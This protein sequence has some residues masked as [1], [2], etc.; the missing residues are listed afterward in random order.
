VVRQAGA[1]GIALVA[2]APDVT[3]NLVEG[4]A[5]AGIKLVGVAGTTGTSLFEGNTLRRS[6]FA[7]LQLED[8]FNTVVRNNV[9]EQNWMSGIHI[10]KGFVDSEIT[11]NVIRDNRNNTSAGFQGGIMLAHATRSRITGNEIYDSRTGSNRTQDHAVFITSAG[12]SQLTISNNVCRNHTESGIYVGNH[13]LFKGTVTDLIITGNTCVSNNA[14]GLH[15]EQT[16]AGGLRNVSAGENVFSPNGRGTIQS[17][18]ALLTAVSSDTIAPAVAVTAPTSG[19]TV[20][21][22]VTIAANAADNTGVSGVRFSIDGVAVGSEVTAAPYAATWNSASVANGQHTITA[23]A[24]DAAGNVSKSSIIVTVSNSAADTAAPAVSNGSPMGVLAAET[25]TATLQVVTNE[26]ATCRYSSTMGTAF[27]SMPNAF[28][29]TGTMT[30]SAML[31]SVTA[32]TKHTYFVRCQDA[33]GNA[34][35]SD[36]AITFT[37][38]TANAAAL[39][40]AELVLWLKS[41]T[42]VLSHSGLVSRWADQSG[43]GNDAVQLSS[44]A[45]PKLVPGVANGLPALDFDGTADMLRVANNPSLDLGSG[46]FTISYWMRSP[47]TGANNGHM[48]KGSG[49]Y[50][51]N[52]GGFEFRTQRTLLEFTRAIKSGYAPRVQYYIAPNIWMHVLVVYDRSGGKATLYVDGTAVGSMPSAGTFADTYDLELGHGNDGFFDGDIAEILVYRKALSDAERAQVR[53]Y[54]LDRYILR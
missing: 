43:H 10:F 54:M 33:A 18:I 49:S 26:N 3:G 8:A 16:L 1:T 20:G 42:G 21:G 30:H 14:Y 23:V 13:F 9:I 22:A 44:G 11:N 24:R 53:Q 2:V 15:V 31:L 5:G 52:G 29:S 34:N 39:P 35:T 51:L 7:G 50:N 45:Q 28:G 4:A 37:V 32:G 40:T 12:V 48:R 41:D 27:A 46:G 25:T 6:Q 19:A 38:A 17:N 36:Y 47:L